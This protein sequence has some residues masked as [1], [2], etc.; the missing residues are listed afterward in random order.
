MRPGLRA[1]YRPSAQ[2]RH[3]TQRGQ[4]VRRLPVGNGTHRTSGGRPVTSTA[5][6]TG[7][8]IVAP[9]G[10]GVPDYWAATL[11]GTSG[12]APIAR[13]D[14]AGYPVR[15]AGE[16]TEIDVAAQLPS[17]LVVQ[18]D[19]WTHLGLYGAELALA[20][21]HADPAAMAEYQLAVGTARSSG[22]TEFGQREISKLW[23]QS[24]GHVGAYQSIA[25]FYAATTGQISIRHQMRGPCGVIV[26]EQAGGLDALGQARRLLADDAKLVVT[27]GTDA[28]LCPHGLVAQLST[29][30]LSSCADPARAYLPFDAAACGYLP[31]E[32]GGG[33]APRR[34]AAIRSGGRLRRRFRPAA[35]SRAAA[36]ARPRDDGGPG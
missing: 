4:R 3:G 5:V 26:T 21:A 8:G 6:I 1:R 29:G 28:S 17:R 10:I 20:D 23:Q 22:G 35:T 33:A 25:W 32:G 15:L 19:R 14:P 18:T 16:V 27:G 9:N 2:G 30:L 11:A 31:G 7:L 12:I 34:P 13:F 36:G 24:P